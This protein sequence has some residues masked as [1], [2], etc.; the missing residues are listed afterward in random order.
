MSASIDEK[1]WYRGDYSISRLFAKG[2]EAGV[3]LLQKLYYRKE[4]L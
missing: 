2:K 4:D 3:F 1:E